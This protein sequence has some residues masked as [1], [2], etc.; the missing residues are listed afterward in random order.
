MAISDGLRIA[1]LGL[2][3]SGFDMWS[4]IDGAILSHTSAK[5][6]ARHIVDASSPID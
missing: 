6:A 3:S 2:Y 4:K 5:R 1:A